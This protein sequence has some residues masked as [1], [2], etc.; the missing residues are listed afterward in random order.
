MTQ[1]GRIKA[2]LSNSWENIPITEK[3]KTFLMNE[4]EI[5]SVDKS[6]HHFIIPHR[7]T[8]QLDSCGWHGRHHC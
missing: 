6:E 5:Y 3:L 2:I 1:T 8:E 4:C 7:T